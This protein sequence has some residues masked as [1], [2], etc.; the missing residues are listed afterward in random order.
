[1]FTFNYSIEAEDPDF[2][3][4]RHLFDQIEE[5]FTNGIPADVLPI[6]KYFPSKVYQPQK[7]TL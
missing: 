7:L 3:K 6:L 5:N 1:M 2:F 4:L